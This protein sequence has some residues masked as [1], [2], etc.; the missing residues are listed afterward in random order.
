MLV[1]DSRLDTCVLVTVANNWRLCQLHSWL[2]VRVAELTVLVD[3]A[4]A[5]VLLNRDSILLCWGNTC[6]ID[7]RLLLQRLDMILQCALHLLR[8]QRD[9][10]IHQ[11]LT[12]LSDVSC[13]SQ[14]LVRRIQLLHQLF[15]LILVLDSDEFL[16]IGGCSL[17]L[18]LIWL[19]ASHKQLILDRSSFWTSFERWLNWWVAN[20]VA[21]VSGIGS[22]HELASYLRFIVTFYAGVVT[23][24]LGY[25]G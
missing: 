6:L 7:S 21:L 17:V 18:S 8:F 24:G 9:H 2:F 12:H 1:I 22:L 4:L 23:S 13:E 19:L 5:V 11:V 10:Q 3:S 25:N 20:V 14:P 16:N 15:F